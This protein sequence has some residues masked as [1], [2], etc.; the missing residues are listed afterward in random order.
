MQSEYNLE[1]P[2]EDD[3]QPL[4][5]FN[6]KSLLTK[7]PDGFYGCIVLVRQPF[8]DPKLLYKNAL[9]KM[10]EVRTWTECLVKLVDSRSL[11]A[12][13]MV[14]K[15]LIFFNL[16]ELVSRA[17]ELEVTLEQV[18]ESHLQNDMSPVIKTL[19]SKEALANKG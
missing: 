1:L 13:A 16:H 11:S 4:D 7:Y 14:A 19:E 18:I 5:D 2:D 10:T 12:C 9:Q 15:K 8:R 6:E 3:L 17:T